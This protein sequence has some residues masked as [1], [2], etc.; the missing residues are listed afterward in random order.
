MDPEEV[1]NAIITTLMAEVS[2]ITVTRN[3]GAVSVE[4]WRF[5]K[6]VLRLEAPTP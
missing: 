1:V 4:V 5:D 6:L 3:S 2:H